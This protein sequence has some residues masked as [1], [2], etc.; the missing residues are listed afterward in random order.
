MGNTGPLIKRLVLSLQGESAGQGLLF[1]GVAVNTSLY[2][3]RQHPCCRRPWKQQALPIELTKKHT[4][5]ND[6]QGIGETFSR[7]LAAWT[8][9]SSIQG[10]IHCESW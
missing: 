6:H 4:H 10:C 5:V 3:R 2:A 8:R 1:S 9:P 7:P